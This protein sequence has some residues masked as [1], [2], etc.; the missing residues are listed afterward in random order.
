MQNDLKLEV[1][2]GNEG[3]VVRLEG[4]I[5]IFSVGEFK[6]KIYDL[7][8]TG[9]KNLIFDCEKLVY[10]DSTGLGVFVSFLKKSRQLECRIKLINIKS[11]L[12]KL[13][14]ITSLD[15][16]LDIEKGGS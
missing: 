2:K 13:F 4:E 16:I 6:K 9:V 10:I 3:T 8:Q 14:V 1:I 12:M 7:M 5:D 15:K 11:S